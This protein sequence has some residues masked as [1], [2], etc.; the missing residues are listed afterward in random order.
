MS[1]KLKYINITSENRIL[2]RIVNVFSVHTMDNCIQI[3]LYNIISIFI[4]DGMLF[5]DKFQLKK[6][7]LLSLLNVLKAFFLPMSDM[8]SKHPVI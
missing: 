8:D 5:N 7:Y 2:T 3:I 4:H 1:N 6:I